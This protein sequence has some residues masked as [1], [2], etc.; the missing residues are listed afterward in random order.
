[1]SLFVTLLF[2]QIVS[3]TGSRAIENNNRKHK[4]HAA[5]LHV[6]SIANEVIADVGINIGFS[7]KEGHVPSR[8]YARYESQS[9]GALDSRA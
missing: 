4:S 5:K 2:I 3:K 8:K 9:F 7:E 6:S 1:M